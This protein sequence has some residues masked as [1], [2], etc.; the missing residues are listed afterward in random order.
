MPRNYTKRTCRL[1]CLL[2]GGAPNPSNGNPDRDCH[3]AERLANARG[4]GLLRKL[5]SSAKIGH[6]N[7]F[8]EMLCP[9]CQAKNKTSTVYLRGSTLTDLG[10]S[11]SAP[12]P[13]GPHL[14]DPNVLSEAFEC[15]N[16]HRFKRETRKPCPKCSYGHGEPVFTIL[17]PRAKFQPG[18]TE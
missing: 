10:Y 18:V 14:H 6:G 15:T 12:G 11:A 1:L 5:V 8:E 4:L 9:E 7:P 3:C 2:I 13:G 17:T 16:G